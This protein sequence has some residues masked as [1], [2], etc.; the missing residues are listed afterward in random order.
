MGLSSAVA[1]YGGATVDVLSAGGRLL[2]DVNV[3][4]DDDSEA[5]LAAM[6]DCVH[7]APPC[8]TFFTARRSDGRA[9]VKRF[10]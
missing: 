1:A 10:G 3:A 6:A 7:A 9:L 2:A 5:L 4:D 8:R